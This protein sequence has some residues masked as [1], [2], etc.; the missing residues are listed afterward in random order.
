MGNMFHLAHQFYETFSAQTCYGE[1]SCTDSLRSPKKCGII[2]RSSFTL[3]RKVWLSVFRFSPNS[4]LPRPEFHENPTKDLAANA[5]TGL[6][7]GRTWSAHNQTSYAP[8][9]V[10]N[11][12]GFCPED[13][14][15]QHHFPWWQL[16]FRTADLRDGM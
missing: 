11:L 2:S 16:V 15:L 9:Q 3:L 5:R 4:G 12:I 10:S 6:T 1:I 8:L 14:S 7:E 13:F